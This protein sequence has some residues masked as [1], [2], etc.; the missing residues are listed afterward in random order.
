MRAP[1]YELLRDAILLCE[2]KAHEH[3]EWITYWRERGI[4][5]P[6]IPAH[7]TD[8]L[9]AVRQSSE[10]HELMET[11]YGEYRRTRGFVGDGAAAANAT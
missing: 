6:R 2:A 1:S 4:D 11:H 7:I 10:A 8:Y 3:G 5:H 9:R